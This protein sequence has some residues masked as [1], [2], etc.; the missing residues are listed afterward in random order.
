VAGFDLECRF[1]ESVHG[2]ILPEA[3]A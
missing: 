3:A 1:E 2:K